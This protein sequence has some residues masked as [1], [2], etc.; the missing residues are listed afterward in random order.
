MAWFFTSWQPTT[1]VV[2]AHHQQLIRKCLDE[3]RNRITIGGIPRAEQGRKELCLK[4]VFA[5]ITSTHK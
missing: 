5:N 2:L 3:F 1:C 4:M